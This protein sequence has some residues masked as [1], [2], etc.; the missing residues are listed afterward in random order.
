MSSKS[1]SK[2]N[3]SSKDVFTDALADAL[4]KF[5]EKH[6]IPVDTFHPVDVQII[7]ATVKSMNALGYDY[8]RVF[9]M[10]P[11]VIGNAIFQ[12]KADAV[13]RMTL[14]PMLT[15]VYIAMPEWEQYIHNITNKHP[16]CF[17]DSQLKQMYGYQIKSYIQLKNSNAEMMSVR[18]N[19]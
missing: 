4:S 9:G 2:S 8:S 14:L 16:Q 13:T 19:S 5:M 12:S 11:S 17:D 15:L 10:I 1:K 6:T 18:V 7:L 3:K